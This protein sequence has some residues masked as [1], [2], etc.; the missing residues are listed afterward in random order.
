MKG[1]WRKRIFVFAAA[2]MAGLFIAQGMPQLAK[3]LN[4]ATMVVAETGN[5][6]KLG[7]VTAEANTSSIVYVDIVVT[8]TEGE[9]VKVTYETYSGT[10]IEGIDYEGVSNSIALK[11]DGSGRAT[12]RVADK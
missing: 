3:D 6:V 2:F 11:I 12:Y 8:G 7:S 10:A 5:L 9:T 4:Q 1:K